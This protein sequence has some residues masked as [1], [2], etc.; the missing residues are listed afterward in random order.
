MQLLSIAALCNQLAPTRA[1]VPGLVPK[2]LA[3]DREKLLSDDELPRVLQADSSA[4]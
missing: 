2:A 3:K 4:H 1:Q